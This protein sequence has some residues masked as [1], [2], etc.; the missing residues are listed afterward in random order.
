MR[1]HAPP[2]LPGE[3]TS[4]V[5]EA[6]EKRFWGEELRWPSGFGAAELQNSAL[7]GPGDAMKNFAT[8]Q[9]YR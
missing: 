9:N 6:Y 4:V 7:I 3:L 1:R 8:W 5:I 2:Y